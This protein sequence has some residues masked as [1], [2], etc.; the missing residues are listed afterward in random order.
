MQ[1]REKGSRKPTTQS[2]ETKRK[3]VAFAKK[4]DKRRRDEGLFVLGFDPKKWNQFLAYEEQLGGL[5]NFPEVVK[6]WNE[7]GGQGGG[8]LVAD[9]V[10]HFLNEKDRQGV[11]LDT[12]QRYDRL[13][14]NLMKE[15]PAARMGDFEADVLTEWIDEQLWRGKPFEA[16]TK[17]NWRKWLRA[18]FQVIV[19][20]RKLRWNPVDE[21]VQWGEVQKP[22]GILTLAECRKLFKANRGRLALEAFA[23]LRYSSAK[24][25]VKGDINFED[26]G[27]VLPANQ[28]KTARRIYVDGFPE[29]VWEWLRVAPAACC[30]LTER[31]YQEEK[32]R[33]FE[34][35]G[36]PHPDNCLRH[37]FCTYH[38]AKFKNVGKTAT[39][40]CHTNL[41]TLTRHYRGNATSSAGGKWLRSGLEFVK[42]QG[43]T[44]FD[45]GVSNFRNIGQFCWTCQ[46]EKVASG[47]MGKTPVSR[48]AMVTRWTPTRSAN[49]P[50]V[51]P[52][53][54]RWPL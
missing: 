48:L 38:V 9:A 4:L 46:R 2:F 20:R 54:S 31:Q 41:K 28:L 18:F 27:I 35:T 21:I 3:Q 44:P 39:L 11:S 52:S 53:C 8:E 16:V 17:N 14:K 29:N 7:H 15:F 12:W 50:C 34:A 32:V 37:S 6:V 19:K 26:E 36:I 22:V 45:V 23:G 42:I 24:R 5:E 13:L 33:A 51:R 43:V 49:S 1:W 30:K 47:S 10:A 25:L 40:L